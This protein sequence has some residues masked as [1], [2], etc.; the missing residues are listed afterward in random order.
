MRRLAGLVV[1][2]VTLACAACSSGGSK[3]ANARTAASTT[4]S[5]TSAATTTTTSRDAPA[6]T[7]PAACTLVTKADAS[8]TLGHPVGDNDSTS[9]NGCEYREIGGPS[10]LNVTVTGHADPSSLQQS[11]SYS[12]STQSV[13]GI[14]DAAYVATATIAALKHGVAVRIDWLGGARVDRAALEQLARTALS[15]V[16]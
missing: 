13:S 11:L 7:T 16:A 9:P 15:R 10:F 3:H 12:G 2:I 6:A 14:G 1:V 5:T 8:A 4:T